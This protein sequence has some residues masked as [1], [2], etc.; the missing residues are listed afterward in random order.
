M[1][2]NA[3]LVFNNYNGA[4]QYGAESFEIKSIVWGYHVYKDVWSTAVVY[5]TTLW[6]RQ[7][8]Y[9]VAMIKDDVIVGSFHTFVNFEIL[10]QHHFVNV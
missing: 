8:N 4:C 10:K 3:I 5:N 7:D 6:T 9:T 2:G 1:P